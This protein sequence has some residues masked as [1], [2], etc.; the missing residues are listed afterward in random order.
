[1]PLH[2]DA[3]AAHS[4]SPPHAQVTSLEHPGSHAT[5][6]TPPRSSTTHAEPSAAHA[7]Q[8]GTLSQREGGPQYVMHPS[9]EGYIGTE[10][11]EQ[12]AASGHNVP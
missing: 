12:G 1:M 9:S 6:C 8:S 11:G 4:P 5:Q 10:P 7:L 2:D 3:P